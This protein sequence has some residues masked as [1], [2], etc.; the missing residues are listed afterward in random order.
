MNNIYRVV[1]SEVSA[2]WIAVSEITGGRAKSSR[3]TKVASSDVQKIFHGRGLGGLRKLPSALLAMGL[4]FCLIAQAAQPVANQLP[5]GGQVSAGSV[6]L[7][8]TGTVLNVNQ[9]SARAVIDWQTFNLG[10]QAQ[11]NFNQPSAASA[12][13][14]RVQDANPSQIFGRITAPGTVVLTNPNG[15]YFSPTASVDVGSF[16]ATTHSIGNHDFMNGVMKFS[17]DGAEGAVVNEGQINSGLGGYVALLAPEVRNNGIV[18]ARMGTATMAAGEDFELQFDNN[19]KLSNVRVTPSTLRAWM[20]NSHAVQAPGGLII[21]SAQAADALQSG[22]I[23]NTGTLAANTLTQK[24]GV[25]RL[26]ASQALVQTG[27]VQAPTIQAVTKNMI[28]AGTWDASAIGNGAVRGGNISIAATEHIEQTAAGKLNADGVNQTAGGNIRVTAGSDAWLSG[29][30]SATGRVGGDIA[31][32]APNLTLSAAN[33][34]ASGINAG[35]R[36]RLGGGWQGRDT[37]LIN[38]HTNTVATS[39]LDVSAKQE[40]NAGTAVIWSDNLTQFDGHVTAK[41]GLRGGN[42]GQVEVSSHGQLNYA[43]QVDATA[44]NGQNGNLLLDPQNI[45][46][47]SSASVLSVLNLGGF[48]P[49]A[50]AQFGS[51]GVTELKN[52]GVATGKIVV[53]SR[54]EN[55][56]GI[57]SGAVRLYDSQTGALISTLAGSV[58]YEQVGASDSTFDLGNGNFVQYTYRFGGVTSKGAVTWI[59]G[60]TGLS[61]TISSSNSLVG[62]ANNSIGNGGI[63]VLTNGNYVVLSPGWEPTTSSTNLGAATWGSGTAGVSGTISSSNSLV[64]STASDAVGLGLTALTNGN[65]VVISSDWNNGVVNKRY[66]ATTWGNG[67]S[68]IS[69]AVSTTNSLYGV[70]LN[71]HVGGGGVTALPNG[72]YVVSSPDWGLSS[73]TGQVGAVTQRSGTS[74]NAGTISSVNSLVGSSTADRV[75]LGALAAGASTGTNPVV[76]LPN[77]NYIVNSSAWSDGRG[78]VTYINATNGT[79]GV[80]SASN[81]LVGTKD[82][83]G[84]SVPAESG[85]G[86]GRGGISVL[87]SGNYVVSSPYWWNGSQQTAGAV[88][89]VNGASPLTGAVS[90]ANSLVGAVPGD[91]IG[92]GGVTVLPVN[93]NYVV[94][95]P[96]WSD[97]ANTIVGAVTWGS[98]TSGVVGLASA[99]NSLIGTTTGDKVGGV[100]Y[101]PSPVKAL[102]NGNYVVVSPSWNTDV[103]SES[104]GAV[105]WGSGTTGITGPVSNSNSLV[106]STP[107]DRVG[108]GGVIPLTNGNYVVSTPTWKLDANTAS[109]GAVSWADGSTG[110]SGSVGSTNSLVGSTAND[111]VGG[112][113]KVTAL[114]NGNYVVASSTWDQGSIVNAGAVTWA[115]G[116]AGISGSV[117]TSNSLVGTAANSAVGS[118]SVTALPNG[119][120]VV[121]SQ[122]W[123]D[124]TLTSLGAVTI[125]PSTGLIGTVSSANSFIGT[126]ANDLVGNKQPIILS[127][128]RVLVTSPNYK[129]NGLANAGRV[130]I[131]SLTTAPAPNA[132]EGFSSNASGNSTFA[133]ADVLN[134]LNAGTAVTMQANNDITVNAPLLANNPGGNGGALTLQAGRSILINANITTDNGALALV[135]NETVANGVVN[136]NRSAGAAQITMANGSAIDAGTGTVSITL[137]SGANGSGNNASGS[138]NLRDITAGVLNVTNSGTSANS[139]VNIFGTINASGTIAIGAENGDVGISGDVVTTDA[140]STALTI[141]AGSAATAGT[142]TGGDIILTGSPNLSVG[143]GGTGTFYTGSLAGS[144]GLATLVGVGNS[145]YSSDETDTHFSSALAMGLNAIYRESP[146]VT[147]QANAYSSVYGDP[148]TPNAHSSIGSLQNS[149]ANSGSIS[150]VTI[151]STGTSTSN[152]GAYDLSIQGT[153]YTSLGYAVISALNTSG[154][155]ITQRPLTVT[156]DAKTRVYGDANPALTYTVA[157]DGVGTS[158]GLVNSDS[159][160]GSPSTT[161]TATSNVGSFTIDASSLTNGNYLITA[162]NG[163]LTVTQRPITVTAGSASKNAGDID[164]SLTYTVSSGLL[165]AN[166]ALS[167]VVTRTQGE[168][169]GTY[170]I[171]AAGLTNGNY[172]ITFVD[173]VLTIVAAQPSSATT[174][175][176]TPPPP[177]LPV[178]FLGSTPILLQTAVINE[179]VS[180]E[181]NA[182]T[183]AASSDS[184]TSVSSNEETG[185]STNSPTSS[186]GPSSTNNTNR[187]RNSLAAATTN[188]SGTPQAVTTFAKSGL[189]VTLINASSAQTGGVVNVA[190]PNDMASPGSSFA[191]PLPSKSVTA[192]D[193]NTNQVRVSLPNGNPLPAWLNYN[194]Q[195]RVVTASAVPE[196]ALPMQVMVNAAGN[197]TAVTIAQKP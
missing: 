15:V 77:G 128:G 144:T 73:T 72:D 192:A 33:M 142:S 52:N 96:S 88:T 194:S 137:G 9:S 46:I 114:P 11:I 118:S 63:K 53:R 23:N 131:L 16:V 197:S 109:V 124:G 122:S 64:G 93:G 188:N 42:G 147:L 180:V 18:I 148:V 125:A 186:I 162:N 134:L 110:L 151:S 28:D 179:A 95:S 5:T 171:S 189:T 119:G 123:G 20:E 129:V 83:I 152:A 135:G 68:G 116:T 161:A 50:S 25:I 13:L 108:F 91:N 45:E 30:A 178:P 175:A 112:T 145:R 2:T 113:G 170:A 138:I 7:A 40:G 132:T 44:P 43:G 177:V 117:S 55:T 87:P 48:T 101:G 57:Q 183:T 89:W 14:N 26:S 92:L 185:S 166:D 149:D 84:F 35:G 195:T 32:T 172:M 79:S 74:A 66:G 19:N 120:Y 6:T 130:D 31:I 146:S 4:G 49:R 174:T 157:A 140:S 158:R 41:G 143:V 37:D 38:A 103:N 62:A 12:T 156:A 121:A 127:D 54:E 81:S 75:G 85:D 133:A 71:D 36:I 163:T 67:A 105:T 34:D 80:V 187:N 3:N 51:S 24:D 90:A 190:I 1:W 165:Q 169:A 193:A 159:L 126:S 184:A 154:H 150:G 155:T 86:V 94:S 17:R 22:V 196:G 82:G 8:Q 173:G 61:G 59:N 139:S 65:Y 47:V 60:T 39:R 106:G 164:P 27:V 69:G 111:Q 29:S 70:T 78:A 153:A 191:F 76:V 21:L 102:A 107:G 141:N 58:A 181:A 56:V 136:A 168:S 182:I 115:S 167:G 160:I 104:L 97:G 100:A 99:S 10:S 98:G 176:M